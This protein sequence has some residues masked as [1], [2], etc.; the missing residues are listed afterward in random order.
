MMPRMS[1][2]VTVD[3]RLQPFVVVTEIAEGQRLAGEVFQRKYRAPAPDHGHHILALCRLDDGWAA[4]AYINYLPHRQA[5]LVGGACTNG[6]VLRRL[7]P[8]HR[9]LIS[10]SGGLMLQMVR[11]AEARFAEQSVATFGH[12]GD[13]RSWSVLSQCGYQRLDHPYL[14]VRWNREL[15][16]EP[17]RA[18]LASVAALGEF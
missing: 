2:S 14:I 11:Y 3:E 12:C 1:S 7:P 10:L 5:M 6:E 15:A 8:T 13:A 17:R 9:E 16:A 4:G 18:L